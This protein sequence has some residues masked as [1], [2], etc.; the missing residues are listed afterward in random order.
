MVSPSM[1]ACWPTLSEDLRSLHFQD[2]FPSESLAC[3]F[4]DRNKNVFVQDSSFGRFS[5]RTI[6]P[7]SIGYF[8][9]SQMVD[10]PS[11]GRKAVWMA[12]AAAKPPLLIPLRRVLAS[13]MFSNAGVSTLASKQPRLGD[14][15]QVRFLHNVAQSRHQLEFG[16]SMVF[17]WLALPHALRPK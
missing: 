11:K 6:E 12:W 1:V 3:Q 8:A 17:R 4:V 7:G 10:I 13:M 9:V 5:R 16:A 14:H 2:A 15:Q